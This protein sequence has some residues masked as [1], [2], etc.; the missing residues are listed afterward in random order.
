[1]YLL[2]NPLDL[3]DVTPIANGAL[4][5]IG[6]LQQI[7]SALPIAGIIPYGCG[8]NHGFKYGSETLSYPGVPQGKAYAFVKVDTFGAYR[9]VKRNETM[10]TGHGDVLSLSSEHRAWHRIRGMFTDWVKPVTEGG[11][12]YGAVVEITL[13][14]FA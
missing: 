3:I 6:G 10:E 7:A 4:Q 11:K 14:E 13:P 5:G 1:M 12:A 2:V 8:L 9:L